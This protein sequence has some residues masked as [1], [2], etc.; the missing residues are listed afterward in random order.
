MVGIDIELLENLEDEDNCL[1]MT[2]KSIFFVT[3]S[4]QIFFSLFIKKKEIPYLF[5]YIWDIK[6]E[7]KKKITHTNKH[8]PG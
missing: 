8:I 1:I 3:S 6:V 4:F 7:F 2:P 5:S